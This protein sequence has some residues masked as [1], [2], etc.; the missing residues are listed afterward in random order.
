MTRL[1]ARL[2]SLA[3]RHAAAVLAGWLLLAGALFLV[4]PSLT[5]VGVQ[6][7]STFLPQ[8]A[9]SQQAFALL[10][11]RFPEDPST[12]GAVVV[13][14]RDG[15][16]LPADRAYAAELAGSLQ[17]RARRPGAEVSAVLAA[18][19]DPRL[20][21]L[22]RSSDGQAE[23][24]VVGYR[25][26]AFSDRAIAA[27]EELRGELAR[28]P[29]GL[30]RQVTGLAGLAADQDRALKQSFDRVGVVT[31]LLVIGILLAVYR[32][33]V[34]AAIP[35]L[36][37]GVAFTVAQ[38]LVALL[39][40]AGLQV[41]SLAATFMVV[42]V[43]G[44][45][46]DYCLFLLSRFRDDLSSS[47]TPR[48]T[49]R[50]AAG[51]TSGVIVASGAAVAIGFLAQLT[52]DFGFYRTMGPAIG[53]AIVVT[54]LASLTLTPAL[55]TL[56]GRR[57]FWPLPLPTLQAR[58]TRGSPRWARLG[59][60]VRRWPAE[61]ALAAVIPMVLLSAGLAAVN[62][63]TDLLG[64]LPADSDA[65]RGAA[66]VAE[67]FPVGAVAPLSVLVSAPEPLAGGGRL[68]VVDRLTDELRQVPGVAEVR[69][70]TQP[71]GTPLTARGGPGQ[72]AALGH[73]GLDP[74][75]VDVT[76]LYNALASPAGLRPTEDI[77]RRY[78]Q[79]A[80]S[81]A[82]FKGGDG[83]TTRLIV[84]LDTP[85]FGAQAQDT[86]RRLSVE[87]RRILTGTARSGAAV[88]VAGPAAVFGD[89]EQTATRDFFGIAVVLAL[90]IT[91]VLAALLRALLLP[92]L[93]I[94]TALL[95]YTAALG[96]AAV[97]G[98]FLLGQDG[99]A[100]YLPAFSW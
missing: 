17:E 59:E 79:L 13:L 88:A 36:T 69:S 82:L 48:Q 32:S 86:A 22:L 29:E 3:Q 45:G 81:V 14:A 73:L 52:A 4:A 72:A 18:G 76:P 85:P 57:V 1:F 21:P 61:V 71:T 54:V 19:L 84:V 66:V 20:A 97:V 16:L 67:H 78:P 60:L 94:L 37:I 31:L 24:L 77:V 25:T 41:A 99:V 55:V 50:R 91:L 10:D 30:D 42:L 98:R 5:E 39:A 2:P 63:S 8:G 56:A 9:Q 35:L 95:S 70:A 33:P 23:L 90:A 96:F 89:I 75:K 83:A 100:F 87:T 43:F 26:S 46:T 49:L 64:E 11:E 80:E 44:A 7:Q 6:D 34:A 40:Q 93:L 58:P 65:R 38:S 47:D 28:G 51:V 68:S 62:T 27:V 92:V 15:G 12:N 53:L 74:N